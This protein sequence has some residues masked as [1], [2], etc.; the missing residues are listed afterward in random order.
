MSKKTFAEFNAIPSY[1]F[2]SFVFAVDKETF[3]Q[4]RGKEPDKYDKNDLVDDRYNI[5][6]DDL[7]TYGMNEEELKEYLETRDKEY[8]IKI[9]IKKL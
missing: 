1:K 4:I 7:F 9:E 8:K 6:P 3:K 5:S 2:D